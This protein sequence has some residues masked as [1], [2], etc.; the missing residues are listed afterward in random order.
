MPQKGL[1]WFGHS[2][3]LFTS[4]SKSSPGNLGFPA[5]NPRTHKPVSHPLLLLLLLHS[6]LLFHRLGSEA[7]DHWPGRGNEA[8]TSCGFLEGNQ[9]QDS[10]T[11]VPEL[12]EDTGRT[13]H[14]P[15]TLTEGFPWQHSHKLTL[16]EALKPQ[17][18]TPGWLRRRF[19]HKFVVVYVQSFPEGHTVLWWD[20]RALR[21]RLCRASSDSSDLTVTR[22][23]PPQ[24][25]SGVGKHR[26][27]VKEQQ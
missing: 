10:V 19:I 24:L 21:A 16:A 18:R 27:Q 6:Q 4:A 7:R 25:G 11:A 5:I 2:Q 15:G 9:L 26:H 12:W 23:T 8:F 1:I 17:Y 14:K 20:V 22:Q 13:R 3:L